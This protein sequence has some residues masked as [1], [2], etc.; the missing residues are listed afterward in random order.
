M[1]KRTGLLIARRGAGWLGLAGLAVWALAP[2]ATARASGVAPAGECAEA[3]PAPR[4]AEREI[5]PNRRDD[6][7]RP[8]ASVDPPGLRE[9]GPGD[10]VG[11][12]SRL[13]HPR[14]VAS[15]PLGGPGG[16]LDAENGG[17]LGIPR[18]DRDPKLPDL[19]LPDAPGTPGPGAPPVPEPEPPPMM[20][21]GD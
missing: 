7:A 20:R 14:D 19:N 4:V 11:P 5:D 3:E 9:E 10:V 6:P 21:P 16:G 8:P 1:T 2:G 17:N 12:P 15:G 13:F 18:L